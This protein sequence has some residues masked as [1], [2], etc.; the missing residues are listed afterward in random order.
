MARRKNVR[1][2]VQQ[3]IRITGTEETEF[4]TADDV[5]HSKLDAVIAALGGSADTTATIFN[6][7]APL[8]G[9]E[10]SQALPANTKGFIIRSRNKSTLQLAYTSGTTGTTYLT[11]AP[12]ATYEDSNFYTAQTVYFQA[13]KN[14][15]T[16]EIIAYT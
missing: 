6:V 1:D 7:S 9:T 15:E 16:I 5:T 8:A 10:Y 11:I 2:A 14:A 4:V 13:S 3:G 12:S